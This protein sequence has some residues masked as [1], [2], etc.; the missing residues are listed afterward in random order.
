MPLDLSQD[1]AEAFN[2]AID[3]FVTD[4]AAAYQQAVAAYN[5]NAQQ[6]LDAQTAGAWDLVS[7][8]AQ[9]KQQLMD[10]IGPLAA[11]YRAAVTD[12][13]ARPE[14]RQAALDA[15]FPDQAEDRIRA[16][17][18]ADANAAAEAQLAAEREQMNRDFA[19]RVRAGDPSA[20]AEASPEFVAQV[21]GSGQT[22]PAAGAEPPA[23]T[24][25]PS[26]AD[27]VNMFRYF[28][29]NPDTPADAIA[30]LNKLIK[31]QVQIVPAGNV[32]QRKNAIIFS[33]SN[34]LL[35]IPIGFPQAWAAPT[36]TQSRVTFD[37]DETTTISASPTQAQV[38]A[39]NDRLLATRQALAALIADLQRVGIAPNS[40]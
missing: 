39:V 40:G 21:R 13:M 11:A 14:V 2:A 3:S 8:L 23:I 25:T 10:A 7:R 27:T 37:A 6:L 26:S 31:L 22:S 4:E 9:E 29:R 12:A 28:I 32:A 34:A 24:D 15:A 18:E 16:Q 1:Q 33:D 19:D 20:L 35:A 5:A 38:Q 36:G 17:E 30:D